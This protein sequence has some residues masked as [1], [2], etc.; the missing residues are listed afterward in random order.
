MKQLYDNELNIINGLA[1]GAIILS[2]EH[3]EDADEGMIITLDTGT[4]LVLGW[5]SKEGSCDVVL[6]KGRISD[7][8]KVKFKIVP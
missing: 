7:L 1:K 8:L 3:N 5:N 4:K 2:I 6:G